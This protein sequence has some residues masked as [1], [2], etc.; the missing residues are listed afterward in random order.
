[1]CKRRKIKLGYVPLGSQRKIAK[2]LNLPVS[3]IFGIVSFYNFFKTKPPG[4]H[5][6]HV[7]MVLMQW[8]KF[9]NR[10]MCAVTIEKIE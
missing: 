2:Y 7:C 1:M 4:R 5:Q 8:P 6:V 10:K 9:L 3:K